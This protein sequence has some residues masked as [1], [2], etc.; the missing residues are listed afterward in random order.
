MSGRRKTSACEARNMRD[1]EEVFT[2]SEW[3]EEDEY[4]EREKKKEMR[5]E[6]Y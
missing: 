1:E 6:E 4:E 3:N 2:R 5:H